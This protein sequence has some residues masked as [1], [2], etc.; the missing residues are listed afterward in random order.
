MLPTILRKI[1]PNATIEGQSNHRYTKEIQISMISE[2]KMIGSQPED[3]MKRIAKDLNL[4]NF[5][6]LDV[7][8]ILRGSDF[9]KLVYCFSNFF[10]QSEI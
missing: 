9:K 4:D 3:K 1:F 5:Q 2:K 8:N 10:L 7:K 6:S